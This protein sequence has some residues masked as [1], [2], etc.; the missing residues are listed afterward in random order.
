MATKA[1]V[2][3]PCGTA[4]IAVP[5]LFPLAAQRA[6]HI[7]ILASDGRQTVQAHPVASSENSTL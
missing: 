3:L 4:F 1:S 2:P 5:P 7:I 6:P